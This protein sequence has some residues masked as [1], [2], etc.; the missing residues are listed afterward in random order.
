MGV[1]RIGRFSAGRPQVPS[2]IPAPHDVTRTV[3]AVT[4]QRRHGLVLR[5]LIKT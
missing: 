5:A 2:L 4:Q 1:N 3:A